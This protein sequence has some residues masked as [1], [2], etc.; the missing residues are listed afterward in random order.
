MESDE[1]YFRRVFAESD[2]RRQDIIDDVLRSAGPDDDVEWLAALALHR[3]GLISSSELHAT[4]SPNVLPKGWY[5]C[6][7]DDE[8][9]WCPTRVWGLDELAGDD[10]MAKLYE[11]GY[12]WILVFSDA[13]GPHGDRTFLHIKNFQ[14]VA[15]TENA[16]TEADALHEL[17][18]MGYGFEDLPD[19]IRL[20]SAAPTPPPPVPGWYPDPA[21][22]V[23]HRW[24]D[25][26]GWTPHA[27][28]VRTF[29]DPI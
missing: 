17:A 11:Q 12:R 20:H 4:G 1:E 25:G 24:W 7:L 26:R 13:T 23:T 22:R 18:D 3:A 8:L 9:R 2:R 19:D 10:D 21:R 29:T 28:G 16:L 27:D 15:M 14:A 5:Y 6:Y